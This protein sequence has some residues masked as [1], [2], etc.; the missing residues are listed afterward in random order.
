MIFYIILIIPLKKATDENGRRRFHGAFTGGFSAGYFN[1]VGSKEG[2]QPKSFKSSR[3]D[4]S[5]VNQSAEDFMDAE[6][7]ENSINCLLPKKRKI[8]SSVLDEPSS[9]PKK[10]MLGPS[11]SDLTG[12]DEFHDTLQDKYL[13]IKRK[14]EDFRGLGCRM[15]V[16]FENYSKLKE[17]ED[18]TNVTLRM[19]SIFGQNASK[20][21]KKFGQGIFEDT[22]DISVYD[23]DT[24]KF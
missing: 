13:S 22:D 6:D 7:F 18:N 17:Q 3:K 15:D 5:S 1:T 16:Q 21:S 9:V 24:S 4:R 11:I 19:D 20:V 8:E 14:P 2:F 10:R 23:V 12:D